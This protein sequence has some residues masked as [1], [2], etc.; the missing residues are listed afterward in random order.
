[1]KLCPNCGKSKSVS[2]FYRD[3]QTKSGYTCYCKICFIKRCRK[4]QQ[5]NRAKVLI[6]QRKWCKANKAKKRGYAKRYYGD[7]KESERNRH[8][9][10]RGTLKGHIVHVVAKAKQRC[11]NENHPR[12]GR[13]GGRGIKLCFSSGELYH[14]CLNN[15]IDPRG[16]EIHRIDNDGD[17]VLDNIE[18]LTKGEHTTLHNTGG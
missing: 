13:Y 16:L 5:D 6:Y 14:W 9:V 10:Y 2:G 12:H 17:Y 1:M 8:L 4:Y 3:K 18:F 11:T 7:N 15:H